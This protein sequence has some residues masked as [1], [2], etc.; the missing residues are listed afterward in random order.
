M[1]EASSYPSLKPNISRALFHFVMSACFLIGTALFGA[2]QK[3]SAEDIRHVKLMEQPTEQALLSLAE[4]FDVQIM[5][6]P[7]LVRA[8][9]SRP[10]SGR[11]TL[12]SAAGYL[13]KGASLR[14]QK[15]SRGVFVVIRPPP[16]RREKPMKK[17]KIR[18]VFASEIFSENVIE[19]I[20]VVG[21]QIKGAK[22]A[23]AL[24]VTLVSVNEIEATGASSFEELLGNIPQAGLSGFN[25][26]AELSND[27]R[28]DIASINLRT[29]GADSTL[30][31]LNGRRMVSHPQTQ[32]FGGVPI[33]FVNMNAI[34]VSGIN[35]IEI[36]RDGAAALYGS[37]AV[38]G[39]IN[40]VLDQDHDGFSFE[41]RRADVFKSR[42]K[43]DL[44][45]LRGSQ[46]L[47]E[48]R[49]KVTLVASYFK[50][51]GLDASER[52]QSADA[53]K[54]FLLDPNDPFYNHPRLR[55][56]SS[57][58]PYGEFIAGHPD[59]SSDRIQGQAVLSDDGLQLLSSSGRFHLQPA[60]VFAFPSQTG[61]AF[62]PSLELDD[63]RSGATDLE[64]GN[65]LDLG[66]GKVINPLQYNMNQFRR[67]IPDIKRL[68]FMVRYDHKISDDLS[69]FGD[70]VYYKSK[71][72]KFF[73]PPVLSTSNNFTVPASYTFNP[74]GPL[75]SASGEENPYRLTGFDIPEEG[76][77]L[78]IKH[79]R[80]L[81]LGPRWIDVDQTQSR[82]LG[83]FAG[84]YKSWDW[85]TAFAYSKAYAIDKGLLISRSQLYRS[86]ME[87]GEKGF[88]FFAGPTLD[89]TIQSQAFGVEVVRESE[90][91]LKTWD[92]RFSTPS[93]YEFPGGGSAAVALGLEWRE[94]TIFDNRDQRLD[95]SITFT[96]PVTGEFFNSDI[97][98]VSHTPDMEASRKVYS[99]YGE[100]LLPLFRSQQKVQAFDL[101]IASRYEHYSD[102]NHSVLKPRLSATWVLNEWMTV[103]SAWSQGFRAPNLVQVNQPE[104]SRFTNF[105]VDYA[106]CSAVGDCDNR[107]ITSL[108]SGNSS[109]RPETNTN[110]SIGVVLTPQLLEGL[111][112][113]ID[114]W[115]IRQKGSVGTL[116]RNDQIALDE[117]LRRTSNSFNSAVIRADV[118]ESDRL[119]FSES[120]IDPFGEIIYVNE[121]FLNLQT[122][123]VS[124]VDMNLVY[125]FPE[126]DWGKLIVKFNAAYLD[127]FIQDPFPE[128]VPLTGDQ[129]AL[130]NLG[131]D[132]YGDL[133]RIE[134]RPRLR[135]NASMLWRKEKWSASLNMRFV[136]SVEDRDIQVQTDQ[137]SPLYFQVDPWFTVNGLVDYE[138]QEKEVRVR[139]GMKNIFDKA[140]PL[141][142]NSA[143]YNAG[144]HSIRG[145]E[146]YVSLK[147]FF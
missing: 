21:S 94:E 141:F 15:V 41:V 22:I 133:L 64:T 80:F 24:P 45:A 49:G 126:Q 138:W 123:Q 33:Q 121:T 90:N 119:A 17:I 130:D 131:D 13:L 69:F 111:T 50:G 113:T 99:L 70:I 101:Q 35:H 7:A 112:L 83:G 132:S 86:V 78:Q 109:L 3:V 48:A 14:L 6:D 23:G 73:G 103:R 54:R 12:T 60:G 117:Y 53:D 62:S 25:S 44:L 122:R 59:N 115:Q 10:L 106:R 47:F 31:L 8:R 81:N 110:I 26:T 98:G 19:E 146:L 137:G 102:I 124:G 100:L 4:Q 87:G 144:T 71:A 82:Y 16:A 85:E 74:F 84:K 147:K 52:P 97:M 9:Q 136:G 5:F 139:L 61:Y 11:M 91:T 116:T 76:L 30:V 46:R 68:N 125:Q 1:I 55:N 135:F 120:G 96:N 40:A 79:Y 75:L 145:R 114:Y 66:A 27:T 20:E 105:Q 42:M 140:P 77:D 57:F 63:G 56:N 43:E 142:D 95:G 134:S 127:K 36:L 28:G 39:V 32:V 88:N 143:G 92:F 93:L 104:F 128:L 67:L 107:A 38:A 18:P 37:D 108:I 29:L 89:Q 58:G 34:P 51:L 129:I 118:T 2:A 72:Y 65:A